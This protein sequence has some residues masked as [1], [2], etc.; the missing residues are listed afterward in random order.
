MSPETQAATHKSLLNQVTAELDDLQIWIDHRP[1]ADAGEAEHAV[2]NL[3]PVVQQAADLIEEYQAF[4]ALFR[5]VLERMQTLDPD[6]I[7]TGTFSQALGDLA[8]E[9]VQL[10]RRVT[11][12]IDQLGTIAPRADAWTPIKEQAGLSQRLASTVQAHVGGAEMTRKHIEQLPARI[13]KFLV[14]QRP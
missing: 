13:G 7:R 11:D 6:A 3:E 2:K 10:L 5:P 14:A 9:A 8:A 12:A 4:L 1:R